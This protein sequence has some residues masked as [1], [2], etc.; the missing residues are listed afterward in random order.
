[1][2]LILSKPGAYELEEKRS[3]FLAYCAP[4][5]SEEEARQALGKIRAEHK[6]ASHNVY[7]Y[8]L[9]CNTIRF[10]DDGEPQGTAGMPVLGV[11]QKAGVIDFVCVVTRYFGG[12]LLG[13]GGLVRAYTKAAKGVLE[14]AGPEEQILSKLYRVVCGYPQVDRVKYHFN[15]WELEIL[16]STFTERCEMIVRVRDD[17]A[18]PFL[19]GGF[20][21]WEEIT[22][23]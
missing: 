1:M 9:R 13:A 15:K 20:Y 17:L 22:S 16:E 12:T 14:A 11:F 8:G 5:A 19:E 3:K 4:A 18:G 21:T 2:P 10:S 23:P 7:A 6:T